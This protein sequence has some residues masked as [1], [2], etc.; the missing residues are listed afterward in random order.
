DQELWAGEGMFFGLGVNVKFPADFTRAP[1]TVVACGASLLPQRMSFPFSLIAPPA[2]QPTGT[3]PAYMEITP[4][5]MLSDNLYALRRNEAKHRSR[6]KARRAR[7]NFEVLRPDTID[8]VRDA[9]LRL[10]AVSQ[11]KQI[12]TE[13]DIDGLGKNFLP[14]KNRLRAIEAYRFVLRY[15]AL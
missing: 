5:W 14:E 9:C 8:L 4:A 3:S 6:N 15:Y 13:A 1:Y 2:T 12:Y 11:V 7:F 10:E